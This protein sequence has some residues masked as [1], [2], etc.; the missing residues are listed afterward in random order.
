M[1]I[2]INRLLCTLQP[3]EEL[4]GCNARAKKSIDLNY[5]S[6][7]PQLVVFKALKSRHFVL[8]AVCA[9]ALLANFL[10]VAFAS[11]F[12]QRVI[13]IRHHTSVYPPYDRKFVAIDGSIGPE[14]A[15]SEIGSVRVSG[16][17]Q[18]GNGEDQFLIAESNFTRGT[19]LPAWTDDMLFYL[20]L[21]REGNSTNLSNT[22]NSHYEAVTKAFGAYL[23]CTELEFGVNFDAALNPNPNSNNYGHPARTSVNI[24]IPRDTG[25]IH[26]SGRYNST[27]AISPFFE[28]DPKSLQGTRACIKGAS[29]L[30]LVF[31]LRSRKNS[32]QEE[33]E[34][35]MRTVILGWVRDPQG[36][37][38]T[39]GV[40]ELSRENSLFIQ[41][42]PRLQTG[43]AKIRVDASGRLQQK[44]RELALS[45]PQGM[46]KPFSGTL[47]CVAWLQ[48]VIMSEN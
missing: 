15:I 19:P 20:P 42:Q 1:W 47:T 7:P 4:Q 30:E 29:A 22:N 38:V 6:L 8:A 10:A 41:C 48:C 44:V 9:M 26:C 27:V 39:G 37:C 32:T 17:Y 11:L 21:F 33:A 16:A 3:L 25:N 43:S 12:N 46:W 36:S 5:S 24:T 2:L 13:D 23:S 28:P 31:Q 40:T 35:C 34:A 45:F 14:H 18:G